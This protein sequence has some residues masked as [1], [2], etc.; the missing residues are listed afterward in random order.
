MNGRFGRRGQ[1]RAAWATAFVVGAA[2]VVGLISGP[3]ER[4]AAEALA[5]ASSGQVRANGASAQRWDVIDKVITKNYTNKAKRL[6]SCTVGTTGSRCA[7]TVTTSYTN[8]W[9][10]ALGLTVKSLASSLGWSYAKSTGYSTTCT[11]PVMKKGQTWSMYPR[12]S[13]ATY[14]IRHTTST[15]RRTTS[16]KSG[17]LMSFKAATNS[18]YCELK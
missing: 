9:Q 13:K 12:G 5:R 1:S 6:S 11:S 7:A 18:I 17:K 10:V 2:V 15:Q 8:T 14:K 16:T 4:A 3:P